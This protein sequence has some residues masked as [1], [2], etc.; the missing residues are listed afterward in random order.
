MVAEATTQKELSA[1]T[2]LLSYEFRDINLLNEALRHSSFVNE[3]P[4]SDL[5][6]NERFEFL[7]DAVLNL[8]IGH[9][10]M[11]KNPDLREGELSRMRAN[12]VN[13]SQLSRVARR[14][15]L[16]AHIQLGKGEL[17]SAGQEKES[18]LAN[19]LEAV[20]AAIY[21]DS[22]YDATRHTI[23]LHFSPLIERDITTTPH[24]D[25][26]S[27]LQERLQTTHGIPPCYTVIGETGPDHNKTFSVQLVIEDLT[28]EGVGRS[29][30]IAE[31]DAARHALDML[32]KNEDAR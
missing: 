23:D 28:T 7:G 20:I 3:Q 2:G 22:G 21:L 8:A 14:L 18:I 5:R 17:Q 1:L 6:D 26:K 30:K 10:L 16:G 4:T 29:K 11:E 31:Q 24:S 12:L 27:Q 13:E 32:G 9:M 25:Y 19:T 15:D